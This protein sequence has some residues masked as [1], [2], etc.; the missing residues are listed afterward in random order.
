MPPL[1]KRNAERR[2]RNKESRAQVVP[3]A[4]EVKEADAPEGLHPMAAEVFGAFKQS[5]MAQFF[6]PSDWAILRVTVYN[7]SRYLE[8]GKPISGPNFSTIMQV[9]DS[10]GGT[11]GSR[12]K[13][14]LELERVKAAV[15][16]DPAG[17]TS[18]SSYRQKAKQG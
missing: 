11:E 13:M 2:R 1:P 9:L 18:L 8:A 16:A 12:R 14:R 7:L 6:E 10:L 15:E 5:G 17:V 3:V 4:G